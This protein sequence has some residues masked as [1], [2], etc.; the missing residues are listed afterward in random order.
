MREWFGMPV[1][2]IADADAV[3]FRAAQI[4]A[5]EFLDPPPKDKK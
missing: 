5:R 3:R 2:R 1:H 4:A